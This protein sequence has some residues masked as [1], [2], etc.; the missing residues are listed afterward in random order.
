MVLVRGPISF[1]SQ[2][3]TYFFIP[4]VFLAIKNFK[5][6]GLIIIFLITIIFDFFAVIYSIPQSHYRISGIRYLFFLALGS[7]LSTYPSFA[8]IKV[9]LFFMIFSFF[10]IS[11]FAFNKYNL[12]PVLPFWLTHTT[13]S[14][15]YSLLI[16]LLLSRVST[17]LTMSKVLIFLGEKSFFIFL[18]QMSYFWILNNI[19]EHSTYGI[20]LHFVSLFVCCSVGILF[21]FFYSSL[22]PSRNQ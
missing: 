10:Y 13:L 1:I 12:N 20:W 14:S 7:M 18:T 4:I 9:S 21:S 17:D 15:Y 19:V 22:M 8:K 3:K 5:Y 2:F 6:S 11:F 16:F